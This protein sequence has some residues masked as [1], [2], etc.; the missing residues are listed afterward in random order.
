MSDNGIDPAKVKLILN[1]YHLG[2]YSSLEKFDTGIINDVYLIN[3]KYVLRIE[4]QKYEENS[5]KFK[6][7]SVLFKILPNFGIPT[8]ELIGF[9]ETRQ[10]LSTPFMILAFIPGETLRDSFIKLAPEQ[11]KS[12]SGQLGKLAKQI[13]SISMEN[14]NNNPLLGNI[15]N[16]VDKSIKDFE[17]YWKIVNET[18]HLSAEIKK[19][20]MATEE[21]FRT[22]NLNNIGG[23]IHGDFSSGNFQI[24]KGRIIG[25]FDFEYASIADPLWD[26]QKLPLN[27]QLGDSFNKDEFLKGYGVAK[28]TNEEKIR[29]RMYCFHQGVWEIWATMTKFMPFSDKEMEEGKELIVKTVNY[30]PIH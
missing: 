27:F 1:K 12:I 23:L 10:I 11:Q 17:N 21:Q 7:E 3:K 18:D 25:I 28:F 15:N 29:L 20:I 24:D 4:Q 14:L 26:L 13:H 6:K 8:P 22:M 2:E 5:D 30:K 19:E 9:D 16:W